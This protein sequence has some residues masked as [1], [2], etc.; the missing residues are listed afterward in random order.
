VGRL[1]TGPEWSGCGV[2]GKRLVLEDFRLEHCRLPAAVGDSRMTKFPSHPLLAKEYHPPHPQGYGG[3]E[4]VELFLR[5][6]SGDSGF[7]VAG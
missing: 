2:A 7:G 3:A 5:C 6:V 1:R 4:H